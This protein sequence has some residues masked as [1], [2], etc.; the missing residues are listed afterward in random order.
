MYLI[1]SIISSFRYEF[2]NEECRFDC[3]S[4]TSCCGGPDWEDEGSDGNA[5]MC[6]QVGNLTLIQIE[7]LI[8]ETYFVFF[9]VMQLS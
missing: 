5:N 8:R 7:V 9:L 4:G 2:R 6:S 3:R 1:E